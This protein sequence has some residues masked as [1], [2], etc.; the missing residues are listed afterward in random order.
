MS[1]GQILQ[2]VKFGFKAEDF[3]A[4]ELGRYLEA[5]ARLEVEQAHLD[6]EAVDPDDAKTVRA[7][8]QKIAVAKQWRQWIEEAVADGEQAQQEAAADDGR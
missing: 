8:Q 5:R 6:L 7:V 1:D 4:S 3:L 2:R